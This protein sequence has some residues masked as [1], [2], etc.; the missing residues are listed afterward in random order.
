MSKDTPGFPHSPSEGWWEDLETSPSAQNW[1]EDDTTP[2]TE[3]RWW[4]D[5]TAIPKTHKELD[6]PGT[7]TRVDLSKYLDSDKSPLDPKLLEPIPLGALEEWE[8]DDLKAYR[9]AVEQGQLDRFE[10]YD[11]NAQGL[12]GWHAANQAEYDKGFGVDVTAT[13]AHLIRLI[14]KL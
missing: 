9:D 12:E 3:V 1:W 5:D 11:P 6:N 13:G 8:L 14:Y 4:E 7:G 10:V 2:T